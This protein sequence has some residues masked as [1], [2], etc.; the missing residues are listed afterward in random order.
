MLRP[1]T[2]TG[3]SGTDGN[4][5]PGFLATT[6]QLCAGTEVFTRIYKSSPGRAVWRFFLLTVLCAVLAA[7]VGTFILRGTFNR[8]GQAF[9]E[10]IGAFEFTPQ[11]ISFAKDPDTPRH[12]RL[13]GAMLEY[14]PNGTFT[15]EDFNADRTTDFG[16]A[17]FPAE[18]I[19][20]GTNEMIEKDG[21]NV[22]VV[23]NL[24]ASALYEKALSE[25]QPIL[26]LLDLLSA[27][28]PELLSG[29]EFAKKLQVKFG[30]S[31]EKTD[32][33]GNED[34]AGNAE[35]EAQAI[36]ITGSQ[37]II[38]TLDMI[39]A[40]ILLTTFFRNFIEIGLLILLVSLIQYLRAS[41]LPKG[42]A[43]RN[44]LTI[45]IYSTFPAQIAATLLDAAGMESYLP[46]LSFN[47]LFVCIFFVYQIFAFRTVMKKVCP[48]NDRKDDD[49]SDSDF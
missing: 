23:W 33:A 16:F 28:Q 17:V 38:S 7:I 4:A 32:T 26:I 18:M 30:S 46:F 14:F 1:G 49:F 48:Q 41:T 2:D 15:R 43:Y 47:L 13:S 39:T 11:N 19:V 42:I 21:E 22:F 45:M 6:V 24:P 8:T 35:K 27:R 12:L 29:P 5:L 20:W 3:K 10:E 25:N 9:D 40:V 36:R 44:I 37:I 34:T 31:A